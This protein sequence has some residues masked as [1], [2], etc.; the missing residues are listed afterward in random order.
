MNNENNITFSFTLTGTTNLSNQRNIAY[1]F[2]AADLAGNSDTSN[3]FNFTVQNRNL[4]LLNITSPLNGSILEVGNST[5]FNS[6]AFDPDGDALIYNWS[7]NGTTLPNSS[8]FNYQINTTGNYL[9]LL[10]VTDGYVINSTNVTIMVNDTLP[11]NI[12][13]L[14]YDTQVHLQQDVNQS[15]RAV[16]QDYSGISNLTLSYNGTIL[17][18]TCTGS[19]TTWNCSWSWGNLTLG[20]YNFTLN[21]TD[22]FTTPHSNSS[23]YSF[24]VTSCSDSTQNGDETG[25]DCGGSCSACPTTGGGGG[26][27]GS[28]PKTLTTGPLGTQTLTSEQFRQGYTNAL[29]PGDKLKFYSHSEEHSLSLDSVTPVSARIN[30]TSTLQQVTLLIGQEKKFE[31]DSDNYYDLKV[32]LNDISED[33]KANF[34]LIYLHELIKTLPPKVNLTIINQTSNATLPTVQTISQNQT[35]VPPSTNKTWQI[36]SLVAASAIFLFSVIYFFILR[37]RN[38]RKRRFYR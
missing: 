1:R 4:S 9:V 6:T 37:S 12:T 28:N 15:V 3:T 8:N 7:I 33:L 11:P 31:L 18:S 26:G 24:S 17:N 27:G 35:P 38:K 19:N 2:H 14:S 36:Y 23:T 29:N 10:T 25:V 16:I 5:L 22:N 32:K 20:T 21:F 30:V 13:S 34:T